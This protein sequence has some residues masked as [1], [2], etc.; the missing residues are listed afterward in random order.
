MKFVS[1]TNRTKLLLQNKLLLQTS[2]EAGADPGWCAGAGAAGAPP[3]VSDCKHPTVSQISLPLF[4]VEI[5]VNAEIHID[6]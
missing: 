5:N 6:I 1:R 3:E 4:D 2:F